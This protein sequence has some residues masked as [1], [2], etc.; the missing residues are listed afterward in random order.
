MDGP[1]RTRRITG[2]GPPE[3]VITSPRIRGLADDLGFWAGSVIVG[4]LVLL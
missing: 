4:P 3:S 1:F 2:S